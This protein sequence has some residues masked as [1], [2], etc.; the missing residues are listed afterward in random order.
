MM[1]WVVVRTRFV[2]KNLGLQLRK[3]TIFVQLKIHF[4][5]IITF[6]W[7]DSICIKKI[8]VFFNYIIFLK[9]ASNTVLA[10]LPF[11]SS[12]TVWSKLFGFYWMIFQ[13][14]LKIHTMTVWVKSISCNALLNIFSSCH[15][16]FVDLCWV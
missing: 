15:L 12:G 2:F 6:Q 1:N 11:N 16:H 14:Y 4:Y 9:I 8:S 13:N 7:L 10:K 3:H 5:W